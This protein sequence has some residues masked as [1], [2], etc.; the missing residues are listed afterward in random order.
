MGLSPLTSHLP[1]PFPLDYLH[2]LHVAEEVAFIFSEED[3][4]LDDYT[5]DEK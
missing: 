3:K 4:R 5:G 1:H 2:Q